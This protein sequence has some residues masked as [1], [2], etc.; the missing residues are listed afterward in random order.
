MIAIPRRT[1]TVGFL[2][3]QL[4]SSY[5]W[6][7]L[8]GAL[9]A[10]RDRGARILCFAGGV[11]G[12]TGRDGARRD[13]LFELVGPANVDGLVILSGTLGNLIGADGLR[14]YCERFWPLPMCSVALELEGMSSVCVANDA[15]MHSLLDHLVSTHGQRRVAFVRGPEAN[16]EAER[17]FAIYQETLAAAGIPFDPRLVAS[18][19]FERAAGRRAVET[20]FDERGLSVDAIEAIVCANDSMALGVLEALEARGVRVPERIAVTGFDDIEEARFTTPPLTTVRQPL[21]RQGREA[22]GLVLDQLRQGA[23]VE[24]LVLDTELVTR[25][26]CRCFARREGL[27]DGPSSPA[28]FGF[29]ALLVSRRQV[30]LAELSRAARGT[31]RAAG[32]GWEQRLLNA[33]VDQL[34]REPTMGLV[35][36]YDD[37]LRRVSESGGDVSI[38]YEVVAALRRHLLACVANEPRLRTLTEELL[39]EIGELTG[40]SMERVQAWRRVHADRR[41]RTL[42]GAGASM[43]TARDLS[44]LSSAVA[45]SLPS[46]GIERCYV[47]LFEDGEPR[48]E[49]ARIVL[50]FDGRY[51]AARE[52][53]EATYRSEEIVPRALMPVERSFSV[54]P[55]LFRDQE[56]GLLVL[57]LG[58]AEGYVYEA[59]RD[60]FTVALKGARLVEELASTLARRDEAERGRQRERL[61]SLLIVRATLTSALDRCR[62]IASGESSLGREIDALEADLARAEQEIERIL[63]ESKQNEAPA[64]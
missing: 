58:A 19:D 59:L 18:G 41:A 15:G 11:L 6:S 33:F 9:D 31:F 53:D 1:P 51:R 20:F 36:T 10:A 52:P 22:V 27:L 30:I 24:R 49:R 2:V 39:L 44:A 57:E 12:A 63:A 55:L 29:E 14:A 16:A 17:R 61:S 23:R 40:V 35:E 32:R 60:L 54:A 8:R 56:I 26:S 48:R 25:R 4:E 47:A 5:Q 43:V 50:A 64:P 28:R 21:R 3:D 34:Q 62:A 38:G 46:L 45:E 13:G 42:G 7:I 37:I